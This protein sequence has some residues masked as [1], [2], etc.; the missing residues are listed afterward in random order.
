MAGK[1]QRNTVNIYLRA[2]KEQAVN[3]IKDFI[4]EAKTLMSSSGLG[5]EFAQN[6]ERSLKEVNSTIMQ[7]SRLLEQMEN[8]VRDASSTKGVDDL[9]KKMSSQRDIIRQVI[10]EELRLAKTRAAM[11]KATAEEMARLNQMQ[12]SISRSAEDITGGKKVAD[13]SDQLRRLSSDAE[14]FARSVQISR[15][16]LEKLAASGQLNAENIGSV[17]KFSEAKGRT[18]SIISDIS[19]TGIVRQEDIDALQKYSAEM[20]AYRN[21][22]GKLTKSQADLRQETEKLIQQELNRVATMED[23]TATTLSQAVAT[24]RLRAEFSQTLRDIQAGNIS[25]DEAA[26]KLNRLNTEIKQISG[27]AREYEETQAR[28]TKRTQALAESELRRLSVLKLIGEEN[29]E[30]AIA[31]AKVTAE[32]EQLYRNIAKGN[33]SSKD[34]AEQIAKLVTE[35]KKYEIQAKAVVDAQKEQEREA[36]KQEAAQNAVANAV[37]RLVTANTKALAS[38]KELTHASVRDAIES[39]KREAEIRQLTDQIS[40][41]GEV[42]EQQVRKLN[43]LTEA[44]NKYN[45]EIGRTGNSTKDFLTSTITAIDIAAFRIQGVL[46]FIQEGAQVITSTFEALRS[47]AQLLQISE[48]FAGLAGQ[49]QQR[50][51]DGINKSAGGL[52]TTYDQMRLANA[53]LAGSQGQLSEAFK[54]SAG[55][56]VEIARAA[57][58]ARPEL[59][60]RF[61]GIVGITDRIVEGIKKQEVELFDEF[62]IIVRLDKAVRD[63]ADATN[64]SVASLTAQERQLAF[65]NAVLEQGDVLVRQFSGNVSS[66]ADP[67]E[68]LLTQLRA[69]AEQAKTTAAELLLPTVRLATS[70]FSTVSIG[71]ANTVVA[72]NA[73][74]TVNALKEI[75]SQLD[76]FQSASGRKTLFGDLPVF[77]PE[78]ISDAIQIVTDKIAEGADSSEEFSAQVKKDFLSAGIDISLFGNQVAS[79]MGLAAKSN[80]D[81]IRS[82]KGYFGGASG[83]LDRF[84]KIVTQTLLRL[85]NSGQEFVSDYKEVFGQL[86]FGTTSQLLSQ[87]STDSERRLLIQQASR[88]RVDLSNVSG[89]AIVDPVN[90]ELSLSSLE[91]AQLVALVI[92]ELISKKAALEDALSFDR[93]M[94]RNAGVTEEV[95]NEIEGLADRAKRAFFTGFGQ[96]VSSLDNLSDSSKKFV[97]VLLSQATA[98]QLNENEVT[99]FVSATGLLS[100]EQLKTALN[101]AKFNSELQVTIE[102]GLQAG[103]SM[104]AL[105]QEVVALANSYGL[106]ADAALK[107]SE[108]NR[109][110][111]LEAFTQNLTGRDF[112]QLTGGFVSGL[113]GGGSSGGGGGGGSA[114]RKLDEF[115]QAFVDSLKMIRK[116]GL[117]EFR[118]EVLGAGNDI[119]GL[120]GS[121]LSL[122]A[123]S[124]ATVE[125]LGALAT[126]L[127]EG[128]DVAEVF[129]KIAADRAIKVLV[130]QFLSGAIDAEK[131]G[132]AVKLI[133]EQFASGADIDLSSLGIDFETIYK[134]MNKVNEAATGGGG[135]GA[136]KAIKNW[137]DELLK[138]AENAGLS[139]PKLIELSRAVG[140]TDEEIKKAITEGALSQFVSNLAQDLESLDPDEAKRKLDEF[141]Q[142]LQEAETPE[143]ILAIIDSQPLVQARENTDLLVKSLIDAGVQAGLSASD[144]LK[145]AQAQTTYNEAALRGQLESQ[146]LQAQMPGIAEAIKQG[147]PTEEALNMLTKYQG[148]LSDLE[149]IEDIALVID[150]Q[151]ATGATL[152]DT[153][154]AIGLVKDSNGRYSFEVAFQ[155]ATMTAGEQQQYE[156]EQQVKAALN[157]ALGKEI[158]PSLNTDKMKSDIE[159]VTEEE[160]LVNTSA[161]KEELDISISEVTGKTREILLEIDK[162]SLHAQIDQIMQEKQ[163]LLQVRVDSKTEESKSTDR[164]GSGQQKANKYALGGLVIGPSHANGGVDINAEG[165]EYVIP[166]NMV[167]PPLIK[168]LDTMRNGRLPS[169]VRSLATGSLPPGAGQLAEAGMGFGPSTSYNNNVTMTTS[170][171]TNDN[172][173]TIY[174]KYTMKD[175]VRG[176]SELGMHR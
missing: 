133:Q 76:Q 37:S 124:G 63:Y 47:G 60:D 88:G 46:F 16:E 123:A 136:A 95:S 144:L 106:G 129:R 9:S 70:D 128:A 143:D 140:Y 107:F 13:L 68:A 121:F 108:A 19:T 75:N 42:T 4:K 164:G 5:K 154:E 135:G 40:R 160:Y 81:F 74:T 6:I 69:I 91:N 111:A 94:L 127:D 157:K 15:A 43:Q 142:A 145:L 149:S 126:A 98:L 72:G 156:W 119:D 147:I 174:N 38:T 28:L 12:K 51:L 57:A 93:V 152:E 148:L 105:G 112:S 82:F 34:G 17:F 165:G 61:G 35:L 172:R 113:L 155:L 141:T 86:D 48:T 159:E 87:L 100:D 146:A 109:R 163:A 168:A 66:L 33:I 62:R 14:A 24:G 8:S 65:L 97:D 173:Q 118:E 166:K 18:S 80:D 41:S 104:D 90:L 21:T 50:I 138:A 132:A 22:T 176:Y 55:D 10:E 102:T 79:S 110:V 134:N 116:N 83:D 58:K 26:Q 78:G 158:E 32:L 85:S 89:A 73:Q 101:N 92:D 36:K 44:V 53:L 27:A 84:E 117:E 103:R 54:A 169:L 1:Q 23:L 175:V 114:K 162:A 3:D 99:S 115:A 161:D 139:A 150:L 56:L 120:V 20:E 167:T 64:K 71:A 39:A 45:R 151:A 25:Y 11:S 2:N 49:D 170:Y 30:A 96:G 77:A 52:L 131:A 122:A 59:A 29:V 171:Q 7:T 67:Y 130:D 31:T 153:I 125:E 137:G